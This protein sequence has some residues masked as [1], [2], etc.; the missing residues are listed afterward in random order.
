VNSLPWWIPPN[1]S[2]GSIK[3]PQRPDP[4]T[5]GVSE[6]FKTGKSMVVKELLGEHSL[7]S[8]PQDSLYQL[9]PAVSEGLAPPLQNE[10]N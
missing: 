9:L 6:P 3:I 5:L 7:R 4:E 10:T 1:I 8:S 2:G